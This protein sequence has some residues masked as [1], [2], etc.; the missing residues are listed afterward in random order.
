MGDIT[1]ITGGAGGIGAACAELLHARGSTVVIVDRDI[2]LA[3]QI[4]ARIGKDAHA[5]Q[6]DVTDE[7]KFKEVADKIEAE[8]GPVTKLITSAAVLQPELAA[9]EALSF[10]LWDRIMAVDV[11]G[12]YAACRTFGS[13]M[14]FRGK[15][16]IVNIASIAGVSSTP[17]HAYSPAKAAVI[18]LTQCMAGEYG[19][20]G[21]R[22]NAVSPGHVLT[23]SLK[24]AISK[25]LRDGSRI[26]A[27]TATGRLAQPEEVAC[28]IAFLLSDEAIAVTGINLLVDNGSMVAS[29]WHQFGGCRPRRKTLSAINNG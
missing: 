8:V 5:Y 1:V 15:G 21:V 17:L 22:V 26:R 7:D 25:G 10:E 29:T 14:A 12:V 27:N 18:N 3:N 6:L 28:V 9:P 20:S 24:D 11:R 13:R 23:D 19:R 4:A 2:E 16:S